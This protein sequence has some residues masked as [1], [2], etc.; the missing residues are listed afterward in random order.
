MCV[1][2]VTEGSPVGEAVCSRTS[3][4]TMNARPHCGLLVFDSLE[5]MI[6][7]ATPRGGSVKKKKSEM[8]QFKK[9]K[10]FPRSFEVETAQK[11]WI[12]V[13]SA[14]ERCLMVQRNRKTRACCSR[15]GRQLWP[16]VKNGRT[17]WIC[18][19]DCPPV[20]AS[21]L[22]WAV[23]KPRA[24]PQKIPETYDA[25]FSDLNKPSGW[26]GGCR[27]GGNEFLNKS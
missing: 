6:E 27:A 11:S 19:D 21:Q 4:Y 2:V 5:V 8:G 18:V 23:W 17:V 1:Q 15:R 3:L 7:M 25:L 26:R 12:V 13:L 10:G 9:K 16:A 24:K 14:R 22:S 20:S